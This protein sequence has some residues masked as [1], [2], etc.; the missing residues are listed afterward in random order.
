M[1]GLSD[2]S[3]EACKI[4]LLLSA[5][6]IFGIRLRGADGSVSESNRLTI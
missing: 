6:T 4:L 2:Q 5:V 1:I 3:A